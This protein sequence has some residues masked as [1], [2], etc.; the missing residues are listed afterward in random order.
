MLFIIQKSYLENKK[1]A[2]FKE[3]FILDDRGRLSLKDV[4]DYFCG[5]GFMDL[6]YIYPDNESKYF[7]ISK[8]YKDGLEM[9]FD[10]FIDRIKSGEFENRIEFV[11]NNF[12]PDSQLSKSLILS[13][14]K[15]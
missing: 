9:L 7:T 11:L 5:F 1:F 10:L 3:D 4:R 2:L 6:F 12:N 13:S 15:V 14:I 8:D